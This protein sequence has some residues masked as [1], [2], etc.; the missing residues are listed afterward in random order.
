MSPRHF[1]EEL[2]MSNNVL[3]QI[4]V[5]SVDVS[6]WS[7]GVTLKRE[8]IGVDL[9]ERAFTLGRKHLIAPEKLAPFTTIRRRARE[10]CL[11]DGSRFLG[12]FALPANEAV[13]G[14]LVAD[15]EAMKAEFE[16]ERSALI[17]NFGK[18]VDDWCSEEAVKPY[19][20][21]IRA[22]L[23]SLQSIER[24]IQFDF[25][26]YQVGVPAKA[27]EY[28]EREVKALGNTLFS[29][30]ADAAGDLYKSF[31][32]RN[33]KT[34]L[35]KL[36]WAFSTRTVSAIQ[37][38][39]NK[40]KGLEFVDARVPP[41]VDEIDRILAT[42]PT[43]QGGKHEGAAMRQIYSL[44]VILSSEDRM[45]ELGQGL[46]AVGDVIQKEF[47][48]LLG[49]PETQVDIEDA[50]AAEILSEE[51]HRVDEDF[52]LE[53]AIPPVTAIMPVLETRGVAIGF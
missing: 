51:T 36:D 9:P 29:E 40:L 24:R 28:L 33:S 10:R 21:I 23:P 30:I 50:I 1:S 15:L 35:G 3:G 52:I 4:N 41:V 45:L 2:K 47:G 20:D 16:Q 25:S 5:V 22:S 44:L 12:G 53:Q 8:E 38:I 27:P 46:L 31:L 34:G 48:E 18:A 7:G 26:I 11:K 14:D 49:E 39:R 32:E 19:E 6:T 13:L 17:F 43:A 37:G 42:L